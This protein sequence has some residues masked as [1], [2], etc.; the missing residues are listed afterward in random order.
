LALAFGLQ[1]RSPEEYKDLP[2]NEK[3][4]IF[5]LGNNVFSILTGLV[6]FYGARGPRAAKKNVLDGVAPYVDPRWSSRSFAERKLSELIHLCQ[7]YDPDD[8]ID[9][10]AAVQFLR[11]AVRENDLYHKHEDGQVRA[12]RRVQDTSPG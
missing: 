7:A 4:D 10:G 1:W 12:N 11:D 3:I 2:L 5:S 9:A 8:R 6:P